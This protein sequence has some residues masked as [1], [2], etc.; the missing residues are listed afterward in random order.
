M[1]GISQHGL[2][3]A[4]SNYCKSIGCK[5]LP[6][7]RVGIRVNGSVKPAEISE[8]GGYYSSSKGCICY[9]GR[10][11][12]DGEGFIEIPEILVLNGKC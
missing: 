11:I 9:S 2:E 1:L 4:V 6:R 8:G 12:G 7:E 10:Y 5:Y 3:S